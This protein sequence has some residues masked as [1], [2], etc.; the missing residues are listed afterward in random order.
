MS[1]ALPLKNPGKSGVFYWVT[2][3]KMMS[4]LAFEIGRV[5]ALGLGAASIL[6]G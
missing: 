2:F 3:D 6:D 1:G 5:E 4:G